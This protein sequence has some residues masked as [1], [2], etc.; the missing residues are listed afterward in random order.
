M[1]LAQPNSVFEIAH[2]NDSGIILCHKHKTK[3]N[4]T[5]I[6]CSFSS[7]VCTAHIVALILPFRVCIKP[8][9]FHAVKTLIE[10][11]KSVYI[12]FT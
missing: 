3:N 5:P 4:L 10:E 7:I 8:S 1:V 6:V 2:K 9:Q 11:L 12:L